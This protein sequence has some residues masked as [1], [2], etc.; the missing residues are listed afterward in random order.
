ML[1][2]QS[3]HSAKEKYREL[4]NAHRKK[5]RTQA[6][7]PPAPS[8]RQKKKKKVKKP[9]KRLAYALLRKSL[10]WKIPICSPPIKDNDY[11]AALTSLAVTMAHYQKCDHMVHVQVAKL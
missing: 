8:K 10:H 3:R 2:L 6:P 1:Q 11:K 9:Q 4:S 7:P 5:K